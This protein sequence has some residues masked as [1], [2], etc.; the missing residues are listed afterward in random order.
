MNCNRTT[1]DD[2]QCGEVERVKC[3]PGDHAAA[4]HNIQRKPEDIGAV[5]KFAFQL[6]VHPAKHEWKRDHR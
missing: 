5:S 4:L 3:Y 6:E 2:H 1:G